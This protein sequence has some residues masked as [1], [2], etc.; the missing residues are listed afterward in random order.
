M[1]QR[2]P[3]RHPNFLDTT[4]SLLSLFLF[5][6][7]LVTSQIPLGCTGQAHSSNFTCIE[8]ER[9]ALLQFRDSLIDESNRLSSWIG[10][11]CCSWDGISCNK[12]IGHVVKLDLC[13]SE[14]LGFEFYRIRIPTF[15]G[16][17][18]DLRY[19]NLS[20]AGFVG[21]VPHHLGNLSHLR[22]LDI[23]MSENNLQG[24]IPSEIGQ[25]RKLTRLYLFFNELNGTIPSSLWELTKLQTLEVDRNSLTGVLSEH[26]FVKLRE[27]N[28]LYISCNF[29]SL[30]VSSSW[31]PPFQ[32]RHITMDSIETG[33]QFPNWLRTQKEI[34]VLFMQNVSISDAIPSWFGVHFNYLKALDLSRN[35]LEGSLK[36]FAT[37]A[38]VDKEAIKIESL[39]LSYNRFTGSIPED[40]CRLKTLM[41][42]DLSN[43]HLSGSIP[44]CLG[45][46]R[47][48]VALSLSDNNLCGQIPS[49][50]GNLEELGTL[51]LSGNKFD[52][53]LPSS[54]QNL[55]RLQILDLG[56]NGIKD[57]IPV[58]IGERLSD[59]KFLRLESNNFRGGIPDKFCQ[60]LHLQVLNLAHNNLSGFIPHCFN[61]FTMM[62]SKNL[63]SVKSIILSANNLVGEIPDEIMDLVGLQIFN[64]SKNHLNGR[65][66]QKIG[67]LKQ[68]ETLDLS[69]NELNGEIP[70]SLSGLN[71]LSSLNL[72]YNKLSGPIPSGNQ[73]QT[74]T[75][76]SIYE[77]NIG[78]CHSESDFL[79]FYAGLG[80]GFSV[81]V[82]GILGIL[83][84]KKTWRDAFFK[85][86]ENANDRIWVM[87]TLKTARLRRNFHQVYV[88]KRLYSVFSYPAIRCHNTIS[89]LSITT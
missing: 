3:M 54:M 89:W 53:K 66:P 75:D 6:T 57:I 33:P 56:E 63:L 15:L 87:I 21:E 80:P 83:Q 45:N 52:G 24:S 30:H 85:F 55:I 13:N 19:L 72:S 81:G 50:L 36:S 7:I 10:E 48:L 16:L 68:L 47:H 20:N 5:I 12:V 67:N 37:V 82:V 86:L 61:N 8:S 23:G 58:W 9:Q 65:I 69:M 73:L 84:F 32:L 79:W 59:L 78:L 42:L 4:S 25:L 29:L 51:H 14:Q 27:L 11:D 41:V 1:Y 49:S 35:N 26:H 34:E 64:L 31:V 44:L 38:D 39:Y 43:N 18:K 22:Y 70:P 46:L 62:Y 28:S 60:L 17:L 88:Q 76:P 71:S 77:G 2:N 74:L 40:L